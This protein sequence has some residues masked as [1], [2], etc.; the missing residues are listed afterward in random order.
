MTLLGGAAA[1][2]WPLEARA[3]QPMPVIGSLSAVS[4]DGWIERLRGF[5][6]GLK[7]AD[8]VEGENVVID[9]RWAENKLDQLPA[10]ASDLVRKRVA[11][12]FAHGGTAPALAAKAATATVPVVFLVPDDPV[13][14][15]L[16]ASL[17]RPGG[18]LTGI[19]LIIGELTSKRLALLRELV[20]AM[21]RVAVFV[22]PAN[23]ARAE[24]Q[25]RD[26]ESIGRA[27]G[28]QVRVFQVGTA[29]D[30]NSAVVQIGGEPTQ[31]P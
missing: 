13:K 5:R 8:F 15:G 25:A 14:L 18:N 3:Q 29:G 1:A 17:S 9:Y 30:I 12:V 26:A 28:L 21:R 10:L 31:H 2:G 11:V 23:P 16:V 22:N 24:A 20:P 6:Q 19:N 4:P 27:I 7:E